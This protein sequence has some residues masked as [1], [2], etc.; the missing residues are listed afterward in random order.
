MN[1]CI[2]SKPIIDILTLHAIIPRVGTH[3]GLDMIKTKV[4]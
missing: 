2:I 4:S 3:M 1:V